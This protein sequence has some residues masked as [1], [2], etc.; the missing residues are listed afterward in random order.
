MMRALAALALMVTPAL[1][2]AQEDFRYSFQWSDAER[3]A[4]LRFYE[5]VSLLNRSSHWHHIHCCEHVRCFPARPGSVRWTPDGVAVTMPDG[6]VLLIGEDDPAW[7]PKIK[8]GLNDPRYHVCF[9]VVR[10][11]WTVRCAYAAEVHG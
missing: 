1:G 4:I 6:D 7:H 8:E 10:G 11:E 2:A 5:P 9:E 3:E